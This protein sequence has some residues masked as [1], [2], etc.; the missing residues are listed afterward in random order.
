M[1]QGY[2]LYITVK[3]Q[4]LPIYIC[5]SNQF[6]VNITFL[7]KGV[8]F[9]FLCFQ[10]FLCFFFIF[11]VF[12]IDK[13]VKMSY[14]IYC[15]GVK[16]V[17]ERRKSMKSTKIRMIFCDVDGTLLLRNSNKID[18]SVFRTIKQA[19]SSNVNICIASGR[20]YPDLKQLFKPVASDVTFICSDG[21]LVVE[22]DNLSHSVPL[23]KPQVA[24]MSRTYKNDYEAMVIYA[25]DYTYYLSD[26]IFFDFGNKISSD[27]VY[28][29]PGD[30]FKVAFYK[31]SQKA[32]IK[33]ENLGVKSGIL[34]KVYK[35]PLWT[36]YIKS[37]VDKGTAASIV[38]RMYDVSIAE[39]AAFGDNLN[40][41]G[42]LRRARVSYAA[43]D[44]H[45]E[46]IKMCKFKTNN[47]I[48]EISNIIEKG[49]RY[50][51]L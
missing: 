19:V 20:S 26:K 36:E 37:G 10:F 24:C 12:P 39:T 5:C 50:E 8:A 11:S 7:R 44:A 4:K 16:V 40:D 43:N 51:Y 15:I 18:D 38:Q 45:Y 1:C 47:V 29:V 25:K 30:V 21:A 32:E 17:F 33:L 42:M 35:D 27:E 49:D 2:Y 46:V 28:S 14:H 48:K 13:L 41:L 31:L 23:S 34:N 3:K 6:L 9:V 22:K